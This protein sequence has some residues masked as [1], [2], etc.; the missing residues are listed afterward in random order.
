MT[1]GLHA[2]ETPSF[3]AYRSPERGWTCFGCTSQ[4]GRPLGGD[5]YTLA[6]LLWGIPTG[7]PQFLELRT[8]L[9]TLFGV[10]RD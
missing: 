6:S 8:G 5:I 2:D 4:D 3:H 7:G 9:D 10:H 1:T